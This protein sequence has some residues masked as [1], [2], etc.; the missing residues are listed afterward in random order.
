[1]AQAELTPEQEKWL[2]QIQTTYRRDFFRR[3]ILNSRPENQAIE[4]PGDVTWMR[5]IADLERMVADIHNKTSKV[6]NFMHSLA[7]V[8]KFSAGEAEKV[9]PNKRK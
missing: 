4:I 1:M 9:Y 6:E 7:N 5:H 8:F 2:D 3:I